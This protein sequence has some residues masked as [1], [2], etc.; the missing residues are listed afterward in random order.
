MA[1]IQW[2]KRREVMHRA[3]EILRECCK[4]LEL[5]EK[6]FGKGAREWI[7]RRRW[8]DDPAEMR[9]IIYYAVLAAPSKT[10]EAVHFPPRGRIDHEAFGRSEFEALSLEDVVRQKVSHFFERLGKVE[11]CGVHN[12]VLAQVEKPLIECCLKWAGENQLKAARVL[13]INRNT[14]RKKIKALGIK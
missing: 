13:G 8:A 2:L 6:S 7:S 12:T 3:E 14:L 1:L 5:A 10:I 11:V 4:T 9:R